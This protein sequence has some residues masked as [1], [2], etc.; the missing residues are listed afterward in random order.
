M[1]ELRRDAAG[2]AAAGALP[3]P[4]L[5]P[6]PRP[7]DARSARLETG[8]AEAPAEL[9]LC[10]HAKLRQDD[11]LLYRLL[12]REQRRQQW[13]LAMVA[14]SSVADPSVLACEG[15]TTTNVTAEGYPGA[16]LHAGCHVVDAIEELAVER[17]RSLFGASYANVQPHSGTSA[18]SIL[19][20]SLLRPGERLMGLHVAA[21]GHLTHGASDSLSGRYFEAVPYGVDDRGW[22]DYDAILAQAR[23]C[24]PRVIFCGASAYPRVVD[25]ERFR[26]IADE[27]SAYLI[28]DISHIAGLVA[29][30]QHPSPID[31]CHFTTT[32]SYKQ[33]YGPRGGLIL[34]GRDHAAAAPGGGT[35]S[36]MVQ[37]AVFP[38]FQSTPNLSSIAAKARA[39][40]LAA[41]PAFRALAARIVADARELAARLAARGYAVVTGGTDNH[42]LLVDVRASRS[43]GGAQAERALEAC[44]IV[45]NRQSLPH[46]A[47]GASGLRFG[48]NTLAA[49]GMGPSEM[50]TCAELID[51]VLT[52]VRDR[53][54]TGHDPGD[55]TRAEVRAEVRRL[56]AAFPL[57]D[58]PAQAS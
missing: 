42:L 47:D 43:L 6:R 44:D 18:N 26:R 35:L 49:R 41:T 13:T 8:A 30:R 29:G 32:S 53:A 45:T 16:R 21:G 7:D 34:S 5:D 46:D 27:V 24:R 4:P 14:A 52:A 58:Y 57:P 50:A 20:C 31:H 19:L 25:F 36:E 28:A 39:F 10:G 56:C 48:T 40:D 15:M 9:A 17:A 33:L 37:R 2:H 51:R 54:A 22:L 3:D 1:S 55:E 23:E 12:A 11:P 38:C